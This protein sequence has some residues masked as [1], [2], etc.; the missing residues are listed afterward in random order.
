MKIDKRPSYDLY[1]SNI[2]LSDCLAGQE[3]DGCMDG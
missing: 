1:L 3:M 2:F